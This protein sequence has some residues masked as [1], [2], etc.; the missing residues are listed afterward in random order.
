MC[1]LIARPSLFALCLFASSLSLSGQTFK[2]PPVSF[3]GAP[4]F[5]Q[6][7]LLKVTDLHPG[8]ASTQAEL[9]AAAQHLSDTG[10]F[11]DIHFESNAKG[12]VFTLKPMPADNLAPARFT[13]FVWWT[14][15]QLDSA[16]RARIP[17]YIGEVPLAGNFQDA[18]LSTL[19]AMLAEKGLTA[20]V[21]AVPVIS[22]G[23][24]SA[25]SFSIDTPSIR[26]RSLAVTPV[27][28]NMQ[29]KLDEAIKA[30]AGQPYEQENSRT[31]IADQLTRIYRNNGYL[32]MSVVDLAHA[33]PQITPDG[34]D[35]DLTATIDEGEPYRLSHLT[36]SGSAVMSAADFDKQVRLKPEDVASQAALRQSLAPLASAYFAKG[37]QD[38]KVQAPASIDRATHHV[39][40]DVHVVPGEQYR[41][42]SVKAVGLSEEQRRQFD[43]AWHMNP[44]D[45][46]DVSYLTSF[47]QKNSALQALRG[48]SASY[49]AVSDPNTHVVDLII[50]FV[51]GGTLIQVN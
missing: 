44:G 1:T 42:R 29:A 30:Q 35:L 27:S 34:V 39:A 51:K 4:A 36:W 26:I 31:S 45:F 46:Y 48:Y 17:L 24:T 3:A 41:L 33:A 15:Q 2:L 6:A 19:K 49:K 5:S 50:T 43:S 38:A 20:S 37:F 23:A 14:P 12:L 16:L 7:D 18:I 25:I 11:S 40:Y 32:D 9:Q 22:G 10:L 13:N 28:A 21:I 8:S 47:L